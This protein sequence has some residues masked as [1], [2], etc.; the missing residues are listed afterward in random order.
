MAS[1]KI[2][3]IPWQR[4]LPFAKFQFFLWCGFRDTEVQ[5]FSVFPT[6]LPHHVNYD[7]IITIATFYMS[8]RTYVENFISIRQVVAEKNTKVFCGQT[9]RQTDKQM[10]PNAI[11]SPSARVII[12][13]AHTLMLQYCKGEHCNERIEL[14]AVS[15]SFP[16]DIRQW[17]L[18]LAAS[19]YV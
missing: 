9:N 17:I 1:S 14:T 4:Y 10:D 2:T 6:W 8:S 18:M 15:I 19:S 12:A 11:P 13:T 3:L 7:V 5:S 16:P